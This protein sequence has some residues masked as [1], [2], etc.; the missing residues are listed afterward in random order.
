MG[1]HACLP[2]PAGYYACRIMNLL[3]FSS[4]NVL[5]QILNDPWKKYISATLVQTYFITNQ[6]KGFQFFFSLGF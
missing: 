3:H 5:I 2:R 6:V 1:R 4:V